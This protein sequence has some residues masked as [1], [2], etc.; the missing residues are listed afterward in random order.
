MELMESHLKSHLP[1]I[2]KSP[3]GVSESPGAYRMGIFW[4]MNFVIL[5]WLMKT[6]LM[7]S[8]KMA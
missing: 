1:K 5:S 7:K 3:K 6:L 8:K 4:K 2:N